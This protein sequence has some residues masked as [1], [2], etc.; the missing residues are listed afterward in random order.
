M[1][2]LC[3]T[4]AFVAMLVAAI[5]YAQ[6][7][8]PAPGAMD[9]GH[10]PA[11]EGKCEMGKC[12]AECCHGDMLGANFYCPEL[13]KRYQ[14][15]LGLTPDQQKTI[16]S[17]TVDLAEHRADLDWQLSIEK[18][19]LGDLLKGANPD[20]KAILK[21]TE[22]VLKIENDLKLSTLTALIRIK[23]ALT[24]EQQDK[25]TELE[26]HQME[27][28]GWGHW[29]RPMMRHDTMGFFGGRVPPARPDNPATPVT[30]Q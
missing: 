9:P 29:G 6:P 8:M 15:D 22:K 3:R 23:N 21:Q 1:I 16:K 19:A 25:L 30:P 18:G 20:E 13:V 10:K 11:M 28:H 7:M 17:E 26:K 24:P 5:A 2:S 14:K 27:H 12:D 4:L